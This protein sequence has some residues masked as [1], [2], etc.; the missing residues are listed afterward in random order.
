GFTVRGH[1]REKDGVLV[2]LLAAAMAAEAP[3]DDRVDALLAEHGDVRQ[4]KVGVDCPDDRKAAA[5][6]ALADAL[7]ERIAGE[8]V[9]SVND[10]DGL[11]ALLADG[12]WVLVR[13]SGTEPKLRV[14]AEAADEARVQELLEAGRAL[15]EAHVGES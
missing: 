6:A 10:A 8:P 14:Y 11:K 3:L 4:G 13:P 7:P 9:E 5:L 2:A 1:V 12:S 15:V